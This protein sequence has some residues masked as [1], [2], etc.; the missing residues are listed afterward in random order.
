MSDPH[1]LMDKAHPCVPRTVTALDLFQRGLDFLGV[2][3][4]GFFKAMI[5]YTTK[6]IERERLEEFVTTA[7]GQ[8]D[9]YKYVAY[10]NSLKRWHTCF[11]KHNFLGT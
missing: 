10:F 4:R 8:Y 5:P 11:V 7:E 3:R 9:L 6:E 2:P 1:G